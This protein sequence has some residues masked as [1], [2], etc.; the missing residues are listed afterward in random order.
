MKIARR[1]AL[2]GL[3]AALVAPAV[4]AAPRPV[5]LHFRQLGRPQHRVGQLVPIRYGRLAFVGE[6]VRTDFDY[7]FGRGATVFSVRTA[8][9]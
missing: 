5:H 9:T 6:V 1:G 8:P 2:L 3:A 4:R 7:D